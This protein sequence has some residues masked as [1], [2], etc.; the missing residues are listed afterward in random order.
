[1]IKR[2]KSKR[3]NLRTKVQTAIGELV[4]ICYWTGYRW[5][6]IK[7]KHRDDYSEVWHS[8]LTPEGMKEVQTQIQLSV[9]FNL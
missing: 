7:H 6:C 9:D 8:P 5:I 1:M 3:G 4:V 2:K